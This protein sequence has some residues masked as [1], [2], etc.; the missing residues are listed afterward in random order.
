MSS[1]PK[2]G[3]FRS[4]PDNAPRVAKA[5]VAAEVP[6]GK[7]SPPPAAS[8][9]APKTP[10][11]LYKAHLEEAKIPLSE[12][13]AIFDAVLAKDY[14]EE[15]VQVG[16]VRGVLRTRKYDDQLRVQ[17]ALE[18]T[19]PGLVLSQEDMITRYN[20]AASLYEWRGTVYKH[21]NDDDFDVVLKML[22]QM[23]APVYALLSRQLAA[24]DHKIF[25]I[26]SD[27]SLETF[28]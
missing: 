8:T 26:F 2:I 21:E 9:E 10:A 7:E 22:R 11:E 6:E 25:T 27:G 17:Q 28:C 5:P 4:V 12:A 18:A 15:Y 20:L 24:F 16:A 13:R 1:A 3:E 19:R 14:Y 23:S